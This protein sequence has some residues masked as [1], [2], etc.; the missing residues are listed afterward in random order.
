MN[1]KKAAIARVEQKMA[2]QLTKLQQQLQKTK[3]N[4]REEIV[5]LETELTKQLAEEREK[6][7]QL[8]EA[9]SATK[10]ANSNNCTCTS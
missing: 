8:R 2:D 5:V 3:E 7:E 4:C 1:E 9:L 6:S 10:K